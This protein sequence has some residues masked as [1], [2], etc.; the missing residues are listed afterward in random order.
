[1]SKYRI[2]KRTKEYDG[3][4]IVQYTAQHFGKHWWCFWKGQHWYYITD[5]YSKYG[6]PARWEYNIK[7][8]E[9]EIEYHKK[10]M[11]KWQEEVVVEI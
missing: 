5:D 7:S 11:A 8:I 10:H 3:K 1:M 6:G 2:V 4:K 9:N